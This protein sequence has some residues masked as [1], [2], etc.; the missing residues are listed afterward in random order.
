MYLP[1]FDMCFI[2]I[3]M[4]YR[5]VFI[6]TRWWNLGTKYL[7]TYIYIAD[8][9]HIHTC[10]VIK[11]AYMYIISGLRISYAVFCSTLRQQSSL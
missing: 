11:E 7:I 8:N 3:V 5:R 4:V 1:N 9:M 10:I 2:Y 6:E